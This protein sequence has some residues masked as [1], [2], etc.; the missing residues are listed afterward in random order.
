MISLYAIDHSR[1]A[2]VSAC[3]AHFSDFASHEERAHAERLHRARDRF[4][5]QVSHGGLRLAIARETGRL[6]GT[7]EIER[8]ASGKPVCA[9]GPLFS[10]SHSADLTCVAI[11]SSDREVGLDI[12]LL[13][14]E[15]IQA[16]FLSAAIADEE[17]DLLPHLSAN[18][19]QAETILWSIKEAA[20]K[21]TGEVMTDPRHLAVTRLRDKDFLL[22][23]S[24]TASAPV[25]RAFVQLVDVSPLYVVALAT[26]EPINR[27][28]VTVRQDGEA[29]SCK[30]SSAEL[31]GFSG[32]FRG[33]RASSGDEIK[34]K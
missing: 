26:L 11:S 17:T 18:R 28:S 1:E 20:L 22:D 19:S 21:L 14:S 9:G 34:V 30:L 25:R 13:P 23:A 29:L 5:Y 3:L 6:P 15:E 12:E 8:A 7:I 31:T 16:G 10:M 32:S 4:S 24:M 27:T 33:R 2:T